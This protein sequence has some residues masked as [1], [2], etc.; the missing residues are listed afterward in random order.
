MGV[1]SASSREVGGR[2]GAGCEAANETN[3]VFFVGSEAPER[4]TEAMAWAAGGAKTSA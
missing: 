2:M 1:A 3:A 4:A